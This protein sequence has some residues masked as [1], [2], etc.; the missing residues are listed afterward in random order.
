[1]K[2]LALLLL[3]VGIQFAYSQDSVD[4]V[5]S[6]TPPTF[7]PGGVFLPGEFN[8]WSSSA[9]PM[10]YAGGPWVLTARLAV[11]GNP[12]SSAGVR[13]AWSYKFYYSGVGDWP[14]DPLNHHVNDADHSNSFIYVKDPTIYH[15]L[16]N[17]RQPIVNTALPV[18][19]A[20]IYPK[21]GTSVDTASFSLTIDTTTFTKLGGYYSVGSH[22]L[23]FTPPSALSNGSHTVILHAGT[24]AG[25]ANADTVLFY[26][27]SGFVQLLNQ[28]PL[29]TW[30]SQW[31]LYGKVND[32]T[33][34]SAN[35]VRN[36]I[37]T[38]LV[39]VA[40]KSF[41]YSASLVEGA[42]VFSVVT[43]SAGVSKVSAPI[44]IYRK[45]NHSPW[46]TISFGDS[47]AGIL[48][49]ALSSTDP[50]SG[51]SASLTYFW[52]VDPA[53]PSAVAG[54]S[55]STAG[56]ISISKPS[57]SGEYYFGLIATDPDGKKDTTRNYFTVNGDGTVSYPTLAS[58]P[59]WVNRGRM[60]LLF[61]KSATTEGTINAALPRLDYIKSM[62]YNIIWIM[63]VMKNAFPMDNLYGTGYNIVDFYN[64]APEYGTNE[65]FKNFVARAHQLGLKVIQDITP[66]HTSSMHPFVLDIR[67]FRKNSRYWNFYQHQVITNP[68][69]HPDL[70]EAYTD[71]SLFVRYYAFGDMLLNYNWSD[72]DARKYMIDVYKW[73]VKEMGVD[74]F[75]FDV[76]WGPHSR[77]DGGNGGEN[78]MGQPVRTALKHIKPDVFIL[79]ETDGTGIGTE[80][81]YGDRS[82]GVDAGYDWNLFHNGIQNFYSSGPQTNTLN[83]Y[84][85]N[86]NSTTMGFEPGPNA[87]FMR[88]LEDQDE[89]RI[90]YVYGSFAKTMPV[91]TTVLTSVGIPLV[92]S[93]QEVG[94]GIDITGA[95]EARNRSVIDWNYDG[96]SS[97]QPH[98]QKIAQMRA[99]YSPFWTQ[100]QVRVN[101]GNSSVLGY[102]RP[103]NDLNCIVLANFDSNPHGAAVTLTTGGTPNVFFSHG[104][105]NGRTYY[106][107]DLY[108]DT[109]YNVAFDA[110]SATLSINLPAYGSAVLV[111]DETTHT[112][113][114]PPITDVKGIVQSVPRQFALYQNYP[115]PFNPT[116]RIEFDVPTRSNVTLKVYDVLGREVATLVNSV[117]SPGH[118]FAVWDAPRNGVASGVYFYQLTSENVRI[119]RKM[120]LIR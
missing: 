73:W 36:S 64:V 83:F 104:V 67:N 84:L 25:G 11:G 9:W 70:S 41:T 21:V 46:A 92:Y 35:V 68:N 106:A 120:L 18:I 75:R 89:D 45:V 98:Y 53:N 101:T 117:Q 17:Q 12:S 61:F 86:G 96:K 62:G 39:S 58:N 31:M 52:S 114:L 28:T 59:S 51:Q 88:F 115:N 94:W 8:G 7:P 22:H 33:I 2:N 119:M 30:E 57:V 5:F 43:D 15:F 80:V 76:Y 48:L 81:I 72:L 49:S 19:S 111:L 24:I 1:M 74:G 90:A 78:E 87:Y 71:D 40:A 97:L 103:L 116:T 112:L 42:N 107:S 110:G 34:T 95:K 60:Y 100:Q 23:V 4:V 16:P 82:G 93:G 14:N 66:N 6:Y 113:L 13:G 77:A 99:Q 108:N 32:S 69:Y 38:F 47:S 79:G 20:Y 50:D 91:A 26:I 54:V 55:G 44:T 29:T 56:Q 109:V 3:L 65:D 118:H 37:D 102:T 105:V 10:Q 63:P 27:Q 85:L